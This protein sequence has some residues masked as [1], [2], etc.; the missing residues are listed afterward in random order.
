[1]TSLFENIFLE[2][3]AAVIIYTAGVLTS[4]FWRKLKKSKEEEKLKQNVKTALAIIYDA[5]KSLPGRKRGVEKLEYAVKEFM[6]ETK[7]DDYEKAQSYIIQIFNLTR[8]SKV[9]FPSKK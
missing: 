4:K 8:L 9:D 2:V 6:K 5:E 7:I 3:L 1:M